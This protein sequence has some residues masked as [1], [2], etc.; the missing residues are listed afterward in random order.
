VS[1]RWPWWRDAVF[2]QIYPRSFADSDGDGIGDLPGIINRLDHLRGGTDSLGVDAIW[3][4]PFYPSP[5]ADFGYDI[6]DFRDVDPLFGTLDDVRRLISACHRRGL[7]VIVDLV[8]NHTSDRHPWFVESRSSR[9]NARRDWYVWR[10]SRDGGPPNNWRSEFPAIGPAWTFD[11]PTGE[12]YLHSFLPQQPDL[13][14]D[15]P[16]VEAAL[17]DVVRFWLEL[18]VDGFRG[19]VIYKIAKDPRLRDNPSV[20]EGPGVLKEGRR[21]EDWPSVHVRLRSLRRLLRSYGDRVMVGE[22]YL[23]DPVRIAS[24]I[25]TGLELD[26]AHNFQFLNL[27]WSAGGFR[28]SVRE[29]ERLAKPRGWPAWCLNNHDHTR[30]AT[31]Y[32][33]EPAARVAAMMLL[34]LRGTP[35]LYQGEELGLRDGVIPPGRVVDVD[36]RDPERC[37]IPWQS[38]SIAGPGA[39]FTTGEPWLPLPPNPEE[40]NVA[41]QLQDPDSVLNLYRRLL[42]LRHA[43]VALRSGRQ[44]VIPTG[45]ENVLAYVRR[46]RSAPITIALNFANRPTVVAVNATDDSLGRVLVGTN[47]SREGEVVNLA[48]LELAPR[49]GLVIQARGRR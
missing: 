13:N 38:P 24:Y 37:P 41:R 47:R 22:V 19:D 26:L 15:N 49:S 36:G 7:R 5:M 18:G 27:S 46:G 25:R 23:L 10:A 1:G 48:A 2:Y 4:S 21:D 9:T 29:F 3:L 44:D 34:T 8:P 12:W 39:G 32:P 20:I 42:E 43:R 31:R 16:A 28:R 14:W 6:A 30:V 45:D 11:E 33:G 40:R 17:H 35:F